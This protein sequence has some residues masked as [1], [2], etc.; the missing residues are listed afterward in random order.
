MKKHLLFLFIII[1]QSAFAM[2]PP[3][4]HTQQIMEVYRKFA[5]LSGKCCCGSTPCRY[6]P[7][8]QENV[9]KE[10]MQ[11]RKPTSYKF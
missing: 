8:P 9:V 1:A 5:C 10:H 3:T 4:T 11:E 6:K 2:Y 7:L